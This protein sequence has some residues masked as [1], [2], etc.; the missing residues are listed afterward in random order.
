[1]AGLP[2]AHEFY[3]CIRNKLDQSCL[4]FNKRWFLKY[5]EVMLKILYDENHKDGIMAL[6][7]AKD[8]A[9]KNS[10][11]KPT[12]GTREK[13]HRRTKKQIQHDLA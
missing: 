9:P 1:M 10:L 12:D 6:H 3:I 2:C 4:K 8:F 11:S 13:I 7:L 5:D